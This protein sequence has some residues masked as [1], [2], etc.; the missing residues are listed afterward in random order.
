MKLFIAEDDVFFRRLLVQIL[1]SAYE[2]VTT[3]DGND[4]WAELQKPDAPRL[5]ILDWVMPGLT[6]PE[7]CRKVRASEPLSSAYL[8]ILTAKNSTADI[9]AGL[10]AGADDYISK[11]PDPEVL[12]ARVKLGERVLNLQNSSESQ[13]L[14]A[15]RLIA[16]RQRVRELAAGCQQN[17]EIKIANGPG[18]CAVEAYLDRVQP[19]DSGCLD[20]CT[21]IVKDGLSLP[22]N[23]KE[24]TP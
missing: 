24:N 11:P 12:R 15:S 4:A 23:S 8:I 7:I 16:Q 17:R 6:G 2:L 10:R 1:G 21:K 22:I 5:A 14:A 18:R 9:V 13:E 19:Q 3:D 20:R